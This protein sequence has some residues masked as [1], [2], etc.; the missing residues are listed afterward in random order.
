MEGNASVTQVSKPGASPEQKRYGAVLNVGMKIGLA[1][2]V[3]TFILYLTGVPKPHIPVDEVSN[4]W[5]LKVD[6]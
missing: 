2:L 4:N 6:K 3:V 1:V 5:T